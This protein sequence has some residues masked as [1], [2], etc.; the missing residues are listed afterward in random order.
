MD[1]A[2]ALFILNLGGTYWEKGTGFGARR[3][4]GL[5]SWETRQ[6]RANGLS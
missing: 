4:G 1:A 2:R 6:D 5:G 3:G